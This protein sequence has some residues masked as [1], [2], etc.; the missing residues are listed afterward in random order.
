MSSR[1]NSAW[2]SASRVC[3]LQTK[4]KTSKAKQKK[5]QTH[6]NLL[7][8]TCST[9]PANKPRVMCSR[10]PASK[11]RARQCDWAGDLPVHPVASGQ[12]GYSFSLP[13]HP[14]HSVSVVPTPHITTPLLLEGKTN[15]CIPPWYIPPPVQPRYGCKDNSDAA[16]ASLF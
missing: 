15:L 1:Q 11:P 14:S 9:N 12:E 3:F 16:C 10:N 8:V 5:T 6:N 4:R 13:L 7:R 2:E